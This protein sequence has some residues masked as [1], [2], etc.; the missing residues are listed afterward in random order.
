MN[1]TSIDDQY[2]IFYISK[3]KKPILNLPQGN[4]LCKEESTMSWIKSTKSSKANFTHR[5]RDSFHQFEVIWYFVPREKKTKHKNT[6]SNK[7]KKQQG[8]RVHSF[9]NLKLRWL[10]VS[11]VH[12]EKTTLSCSHTKMGLYPIHFSQ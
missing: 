2:S 12:R 10:S 8:P 3:I 9:H 11:I 4:K 7:I 1:W 6:S 5:Y